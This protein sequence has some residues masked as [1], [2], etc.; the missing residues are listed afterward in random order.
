LSTRG[1]LA[2][3]RTPSAATAWATADPEQPRHSGPRA[4]RPSPPAQAAGRTTITSRTPA[5]RGPGTAVINSEE[6]SGKASARQHSRPTRASGSTR[7]STRHAPG[8]LHVESAWGSGGKA[9]VGE[10]GAA[11]PAPIS[12]RRTAGSNPRGARR[13]SPWRLHLDRGPTGGRSVFAQRVSA[14]VAGR[15]ATS[16][17]IRW[18]RPLEGAV[19]AAVRRREQPIDR[20]RVAGRRRLSIPTRPM[21]PHLTLEHDL[22]ERVFDD[23]FRRRCRLELRDQV[24][25]GSFFDDG[26]HRDPFVV[27]QRRDGRALQRR[28]AAPARRRDRRGARLSIMPTRPCASMAA[29]SSRRDVFRAWCASPD[30]R[31]RVWFA[32]S[33][34]FRLHDPRRGCG[35]G[36]ARSEEPVSVHLDDRIG[37][38]IGGLTSV[39]PQENSTLTS[40]CCFAK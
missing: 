26:V 4:P 5:T 34:V 1:D 15:S 22:V 35:G 30:R 17:T 27:A 3:G 8:H 38:A 31:G 28:Q 18:T 10:C 29:F 40:T 16:S 7:C 11:A 19:A 33:W 23:A 9:T 25:H 37:P 32:I 24:A 2:G 39:A 14:R 6:G 21:L 13:A 12:R 20:S 36:W